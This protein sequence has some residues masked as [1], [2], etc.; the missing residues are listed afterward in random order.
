M[1]AQFFAVSYCV[2]KQSAHHEAA[3]LLALHLLEKVLVTNWNLPA[4]MSHTR[5]HYLRQQKV[6]LA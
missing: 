4:L 6:L 2:K 3:P 1:S 5:N